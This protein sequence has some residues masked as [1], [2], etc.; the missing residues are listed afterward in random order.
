MRKPAAGNGGR[1]RERR[2]VSLAE[3][4]RACPLACIAHHSEPLTNRHGDVRAAECAVCGQI[5]A[6][7]TWAD[8]LARPR[9]ALR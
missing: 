4:L 3:S 2:Q 9:G 7:T 5:I 6:R 8:L 1:G